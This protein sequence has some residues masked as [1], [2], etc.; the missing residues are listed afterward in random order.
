MTEYCDMQFWREQY[1]IPRAAVNVREI[2]IGPA[3]LW[4]QPYCSDSTVFA[5]VGIWTPDMG[6]TITPEVEAAT[7]YADQFRIP[8]RHYPYQY[9]ARLKF[10]LLRNTMDT[11][12]HA[13]VS[14]AYGTDASGNIDDICVTGAMLEA[15]WRGQLVCPYKSSCS[16][17]RTRDL[18]FPKMA[19]ANLGDMVFKAREPQI[20]D[21]EFVLM[22]DW[23]VTGFE[24]TGLLFALSDRPDTVS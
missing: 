3:R 13:W 2:L 1:S 12:L 10:Q 4:V 14:D 6:A 17:H 21:L 19:L 8:M 20:L 16:A 22:G 7:V 24:E 9:G 11:Q 15:Y 23:D 5:E 18:Y